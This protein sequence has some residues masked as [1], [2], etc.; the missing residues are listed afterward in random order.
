M[1]P[2]MASGLSVSRWW[3]NLEYRLFDGI[4][5]EESYD[6]EFSGHGLLI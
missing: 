5:R 4:L 1:P 2:G 3:H 6:L